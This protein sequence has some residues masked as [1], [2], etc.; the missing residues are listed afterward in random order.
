MT[1]TNIAR[2]I[3]CMANFRLPKNRNTLIHAKSVS[4]W[5]FIYN[6]A[7]FCVLVVT[8]ID[9]A[10]SAAM[11]TAAY[12]SLAIE[13]LSTY[14]DQP[15]FISYNLVSIF[16]ALPFPLFLLFL[17]WLLQIYQYKNIAIPHM[18]SHSQLSAPKISIPIKRTLKLE[19]DYVK[20][21]QLI[22][23]NLD[24]QIGI[25]HEL[26][27]Q[28][29]GIV[30]P[31]ELDFSDLQLDSEDNRR[32]LVKWTTKENNNNNNNT[33]ISQLKSLERMTIPGS[34]RRG[35]PS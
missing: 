18:L 34:M 25:L 10:Q 21:I 13:L 11:A 35:G 24:M 4:V 27:R 15:I 32:R 1:N 30:A 19:E 17:E 23:V 6:R 22:G 8:H 5:L 3:V 9:E 20:T 2:S 14:I 29:Y 28:H 31:L 33:Q 7:I 26:S 16:F 12:L